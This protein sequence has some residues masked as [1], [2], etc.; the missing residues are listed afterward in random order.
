MPIMTTL[1]TGRKSGLGSE[2][3]SREKDPAACSS[4]SRRFAI[5]SWATI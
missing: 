4:R 2:A 1:V 3:E 5:Q